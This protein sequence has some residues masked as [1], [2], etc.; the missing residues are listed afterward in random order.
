MAKNVQFSGASAI[1]PEGVLQSIVTESEINTLRE[2]HQYSLEET[3][4]RGKLWSKHKD[5]YVK[6]KSVLSTIGEKNHAQNNGT[7]G[8]QSLHGRYPCTHK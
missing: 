1:S 3:R 6:L 4:K 5:E 8:K 7:F 2:T